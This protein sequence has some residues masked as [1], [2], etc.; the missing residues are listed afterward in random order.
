MPEPS[1]VRPGRAPGSGSARGPTWGSLGVRVSV[2]SDLGEP[3]G[4]GPCGVCPGGALGSGSAQ[5]SLSRSGSQ[6]RAAAPGLPGAG[7]Q[8]SSGPLGAWAALATPRRLQVL[9]SPPPPCHI[10][11]SWEGPVG[12]GRRLLLRELL[13][14]T[15]PGGAVGGGLEGRGAGSR[16]AGSRAATVGNLCTHPCICGASPVSWHKACC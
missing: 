4:Q 9:G 5:C 15:Q 6:S 1:G 7:P 2:G 14:V 8:G 3:R 16:A 13:Q 10:T 11:A 12:P